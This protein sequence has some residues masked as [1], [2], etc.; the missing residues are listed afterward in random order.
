[1]TAKVF[2]IVFHSEHINFIFTYCGTTKNI[3]KETKLYDLI[4][5]RRGPWESGGTYLPLS[6]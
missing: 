4:I 3:N 5:N 2:K 1:M 6:D